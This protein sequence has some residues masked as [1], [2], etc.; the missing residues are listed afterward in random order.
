MPTS[1]PF[2]LIIA[3]TI[4]LGFVNTH[5]RHVMNFQGASRRYFLAIQI[6]MLCGFLV[7]IGLLGYYF[8][9]VAWYLPL[10]LL[11]VGS[12]VAGTLFGILDAKIGPLGVSMIA[13]VGW[14]A[15]AV[16]AAFIIHGINLTR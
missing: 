12:L 10:V 2:D 15:S 11:A 3:W 14:P 9:Q 6:S 4:F 8:V 5:Q 1:M 13:F 7:G 16:W